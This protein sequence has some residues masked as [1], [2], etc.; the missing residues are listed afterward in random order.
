MPRSRFPGVRTREISSALER[1][2]ARTAGQGPEV[3][4]K[5]Q[6]GGG[7]AQTA[8][9]LAQRQPPSK[10]CVTAHRSSPP[11]P[12]IHRDSSAPPKPRIH[13]FELWVVGERPPQRRRGTARAPGARRSENA[14]VSSEGGW[15]SPPP[16]G[17]GFQGEVR[18]PWVSRDLSRGREAQAM[19]NISI[20]RSPSV[21]RGGDGAARRDRA[22]GRARPP[23]IGRRAQ[24]ARR[25]PG[26]R[27]GGKG[28]TPSTKP[29]ERPTRKAASN[30]NR[31]AART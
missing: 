6:Q 2:T 16:Y 26:P 24:E 30:P 27:R 14:G 31:R 13:S 21:G 29:A 12:T 19:D 5:C 15:E 28:E 17:Q 23:G 9:M 22:A 18:P 3:R 4:A 20:V 11:A 7:E 1:E 8:G 10:E 25:E